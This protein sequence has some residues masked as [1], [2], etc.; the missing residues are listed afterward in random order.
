MLSCCRGMRRGITPSSEGVV[1]LGGKFPSFMNSPGVGLALP[2]SLYLPLPYPH[3]LSSTSRHVNLVAILVVHVQPSL[4][5]PFSQHHS[6]VWLFTHLGPLPP[7]QRNIH[8]MSTVN[9]GLGVA[10]RA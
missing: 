6:S 7:F 8:G 1:N 10:G 2:V 5:W 9:T 3:H 4:A